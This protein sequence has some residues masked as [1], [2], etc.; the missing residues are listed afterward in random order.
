[1]SLFKKLFSKKKTSVS[2]EELIEKLVCPSCWGW[3]EYQDTFQN[4]EMDINQNAPYRKAFIQQFV[5]K[6]ITGIRLEAKGE[7]LQCPTCRKE[8]EKVRNRN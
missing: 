3:Q 1:M 2:E 7:K 4:K 6:N 5:E 8:Y